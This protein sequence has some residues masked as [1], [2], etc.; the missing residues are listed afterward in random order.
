MKNT[1]RISLLIVLLAALPLRGYAG[2]PMSPCDAHHGGSAV[3]QEHVHENGDS[4]HD[5]SG[6]GGGTQTQPAS[7][8]SHCVSCCASTS[9]AQDA[10]QVAELQAT[11]SDR[12][13]FFHRRSSG[14]VP[15]RLDRPPLTS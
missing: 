5:E 2:V 12:I 4:H 11:G 13:A 7:V 8:C 6:D 10:P 15:E 9:L 14:F 3:A 1:V